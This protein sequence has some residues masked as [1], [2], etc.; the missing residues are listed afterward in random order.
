MTRPSLDCLFASQP[1]A[2]S[3]LSN[4]EIQPDQLVSITF[5]S[6][7]LRINKK[8]KNKNWK[9]EKQRH[10]CTTKNDCR[11]GKRFI[12]IMWRIVWYY[13]GII[14]SPVI[15]LVYYGDTIWLTTAGIAL[16]WLFCFFWLL[17]DYWGLIE[18]KIGFSSLVR[19]QTL[20]CLI[21]YWWRW[22]HTVIY[23]TVN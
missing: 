10:S 2:W 17:V 18:A 7:E 21:A 11:I 5:W 6:P 12:F 4:S 15:M 1:I 9:S 20:L 19:L 22:Y 8:N 23:L 14:L 13:S 3:N 16:F